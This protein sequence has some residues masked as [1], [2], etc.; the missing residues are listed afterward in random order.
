MSDVVDRWRHLLYN[1][2]GYA[3]FIIPVDTLTLLV[4]PFIKSELVRKSLMS[5]SVEEL[6]LENSR[7]WSR[8][9]N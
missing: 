9:V 6:T 7:V 5:G 4:S 8:W 1:T 2:G 3:Y